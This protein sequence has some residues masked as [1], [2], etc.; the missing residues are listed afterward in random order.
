MADRF[1]PADVPCPKCSKRQSR[2]LDSN[3]TRD[4]S[5]R[6]RRQCGCGYRY[7]TFE[8]IGHDPSRVSRKLAHIEILIEQLRDELNNPSPQGF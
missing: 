4:G 7:T 3:G 6:R 5:V 2:V 8:H 1:A